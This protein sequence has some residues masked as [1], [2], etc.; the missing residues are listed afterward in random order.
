MSEA[1]RRC[2]TCARSAEEMG[3]LAV[4]QGMLTLH[5]SAVRKVLMGVTTPEE[6]LRVA[7]AGEDES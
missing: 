1:L 7:H 4:S 6:V 3:A 2:S 5:E